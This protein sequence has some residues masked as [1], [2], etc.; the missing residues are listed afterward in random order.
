MRRA[1]VQIQ[2]P[3]DGTDL[4]ANNM[5]SPHRSEVSDATAR[6]WCQLLVDDCDASVCMIAQE[7]GRDHWSV[8]KAIKSVN[9]GKIPRKRFVMS[10]KQKLDESSRFRQRSLD[11]DTQL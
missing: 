11:T 8:E 3:D 1:Y 5:P 4:K 6:R 9:G 7:F 2:I 10:M